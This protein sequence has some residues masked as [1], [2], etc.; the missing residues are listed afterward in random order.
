[1]TNAHKPANPD[2][3][4]YQ[5][6]LDQKLLAI[7]KQF[8][9]LA[10]PKIE[11]FT[12][13]PLHYRLRCEFK[14]WHE[15]G[16]ASY[17]MYH[18]G[19]YKKPYI[20]EDFKV[21]SELINALMPPLLSA[22][23]ASDVLKRR[24]FSVEFL[25]TLSGE[26]LITLLYHRPLDTIWEAEA[27][28]LIQLLGADIIGRSRKQKVV[29]TRDYVSETL[30]VD[31]KDYYY[32]QIETSFTQPNG[33]VNK[34]ML[35]WA[36]EHSRL[37]RGDLLEL[38]CGNGNFTV[39]LAQNFDRVLATE[40]AKISVNSARFNLQ[41]NGVNNVELVRMSS[42]EITQALNKVRPFRRLKYIDVDSY[43]FSTVFVDPPRAGLDD[44]TLDL[45]Q[46]FK[47]IIYISCNPVT[48]HDNLVVL[49]NDYSIGHFAIFDQFP[50]TPHLECGVVL[51]RR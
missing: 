20:I 30:H 9:G 26:A 46:R 49:N 13:A 42:E 25:T 1:M 11:T 41:K 35:S 31:G 37:C 38:Y 29:L 6:Q 51:N 45:L 2:P 32:Q 44:G 43:Q 50:Y 39:P 8:G 18:P 34:K 7:K 28:A 36:L 24:L 12:S 4:Q 17:A 16:Q 27:T 22:I 40:I 3:S 48:L 19:E 47:N 21:A 10:L 15:Q 14:I 33:R 23:N 5:N